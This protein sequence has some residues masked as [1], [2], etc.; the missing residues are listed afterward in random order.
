ML[1]KLHGASGRGE[2]RDFFQCLRGSAALRLG[3]DLANE[4][5]SHIFKNLFAH[6]QSTW[7]KTRPGA[8]HRLL[9]PTFHPYP[10]EVISGSTRD[11]D[12]GSDRR[13]LPEILTALVIRLHNDLQ[14]PDT[15]TSCR[16]CRCLMSFHCI[17][18]IFLNSEIQTAPSQMTWRSQQH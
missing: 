1:P 13:V 14:V 8:T 16:K 6:C 7:G 12:C 15:M 17:N 11:R 5:L 10:K 2:Q 18:S 9:M 3:S 4:T